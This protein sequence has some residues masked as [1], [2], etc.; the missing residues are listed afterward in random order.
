MSTS[1]NI[2]HNIKNIDYLEITS[3]NIFVSST[4]NSSIYYYSNTDYFR[5]FRRDD[6]INIR[7]GSAV[8]PIRIV[9]TLE[10]TKTTD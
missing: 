5:V 8:S 6:N 2:P 1:F 9:I 4:N 10:Y 3:V 7:Y